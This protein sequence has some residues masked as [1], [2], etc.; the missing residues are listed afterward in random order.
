MTVEELRRSLQDQ[1]GLHTK[2]PDRLHVDADTFA[3]V[4]ESIF[5]RAVENTDPDCG[6]NCNLKVGGYYIIDNLA[7]G[8]HRGIMYKDVEISLRKSENGG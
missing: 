5:N 3:H 8:P 4:C 2:W 7:L 1:Y 6:V